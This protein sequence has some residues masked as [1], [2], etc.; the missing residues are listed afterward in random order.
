MAAGI[1]FPDFEVGL[2]GSLKWQP[3]AM[4]YLKSALLSTHLGM[5]ELPQ[6]LTPFTDF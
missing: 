6:R 4:E 3:C 1:Y 5:E 2:W